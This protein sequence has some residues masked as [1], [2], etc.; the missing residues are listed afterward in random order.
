MKIILLLMAVTLSLSAAEEKHP[1]DRAMD[2]AME[3]DSSTAGMVEAVSIAAK[4]WDREMNSLYQDLKKQMQ[5]GE[6]TALVAAQKAWIVYRDAQTKSLVETY[7]HMEGTMWIPES[8]SA[9]MN[10][11]RDRALFLQSLKETISER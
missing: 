1:I 7:G 9:V 10:L 4:K 2:A 5:P 3:K 6:W 8:A 11:T